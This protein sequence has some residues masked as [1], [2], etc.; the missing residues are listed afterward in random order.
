MKVSIG[1]GEE[2]VSLIKAPARVECGCTVGEA[3]VQ[4]ALMNLQRLAHK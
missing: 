2:Y 3:D 4:K 1:Q